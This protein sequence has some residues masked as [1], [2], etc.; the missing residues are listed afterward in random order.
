MLP[1]FNKDLLRQLVCNDWVIDIKQPWRCFLGSESHLAPLQCTEVWTP[2]GHTCNSSS[3]A[4][5]FWGTWRS[6]PLA[7][8]QCKGICLLSFFFYQVPS[9]G[10]WWLS[11]FVSFYMYIP[12]TLS[13]WCYWFSLLLLLGPY[14]TQLASCLGCLACTGCHL[15]CVPLWRIVQ[16]WRSIFILRNL[17]QFVG[18]FSPFL[19]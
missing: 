7:K 5:S 6:N 2:T 16:E 12:Q 10:V 4:K 8:V 15:T 3:V 11:H 14:P 9:Y 17:L 13:P 19:F 18:Q 1:G